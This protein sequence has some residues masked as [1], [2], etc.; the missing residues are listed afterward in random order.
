MATAGKHARVDDARAAARAAERDL[1]R[2]RRE[3]RDLAVRAEVA[4]E[5]GGLARFADFLLDGLV[6]DWIVQSRIRDSRSG[7]QHALDAV[8][9]VLVELEIR[10]GEEDRRR[11]ELTAERDAALL[12]E[13]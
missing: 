1:E 4:V 9:R 10:R 5:I 13:V 8:E 3:L 12:G 6:S 2:L 11:R 7:A